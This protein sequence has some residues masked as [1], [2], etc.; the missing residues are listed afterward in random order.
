M[1]GSSL[2][3]ARYRDP[4]FVAERLQRMTTGRRRIELPRR[5]RRHRRPRRCASSNLPSPTPRPTCVARSGRARRESALMQGTPSPTARGE[6]A[7]HVAGREV[8]G[9]LVGQPLRARDSSPPGSSQFSPT[10]PG[11][12]PARPGGG[13]IAALGDQ[14]H[15]GRRERLELAPDAVAARD[16]RRRRRSRAAGRSGGTR[17][18]SARSSASTGVSR[19]FVIAV[20]TPL[21]PVGPRSPA[22]P[23][24]DGLVVHPGP[25]SV[26]AEQHV[27]H[28]PLAGRADALGLR[29]ARAP[30]GTRR[31]PAGSPPRCPRPTATGGTAATTVPA[32]RDHV[33]RAG[34]SPPLAGSVG[35]VTARIANATALT[36][37]A[38]TAL[39]LPGR[40][41]S[42][43]VKS[44]VT[45]S[46]SMRTSTTMRVGVCCSG[47]GPAES[48]TSVAAKRPSGKSRE[49]GAHAPFAV[50]EDLGEQLGDRRAAERRARARRGAATPSALAPRCASR[51][52]ASLVGRARRRPRRA[53][54]TRRRRASAGG[55]G[56]PRRWSTRRVASSPVPCRRRR[57]GG[58]GWRPSRRA[59]R[60]RRT[61]ATIV[62]SLRCVPPA[63]G[64]LSISS[65]AQSRSARSRPPPTRAWSRG[66]RGCARPARAARRSA[67]NSAAEQSARS[68]MLGLDAARRST[69]PIS[70]A[71]RRQARTQDLQLGRVHVRAHDRTRPPARASAAQPSG[72]HSVQSGSATTA[73]PG[74]G[75][76]SGSGRSV[77][78]ERRGARA[79]APQRDDLDVDAGTRVP[80]ASL[81][82]GGEL[83]DVGH[84]ELV[85]LARVPAVEPFVDVTPGH[86]RGGTRGRCGAALRRG[87]RGTPASATTRRSLA[88]PARRGCRV[89][90]TRRH[91]A[92]RPRVPMP[93]SSAT[94]HAC[95][96]PAPPNASSA[97][98]TRIDA[99]LDRDHPHRARHRGVDDRD[100]AF[101]RHA[102]TVERGASG[103]DVE[104]P[105]AGEL[106]ARRDAARAPGRRR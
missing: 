96:G 103:G 36:V 17:N 70:S 32:R 18:G 24:A 78:V 40:C 13:V 54:A 80:V 57:R 99:V 26:A 25:G 82:H 12:P 98:V 23:T 8:H 7:Q 93:S 73:G 9:A 83:V 1:I 4:R 43:P 62:R 105:E 16:A 22:L 106:R 21:M 49:R 63:N 5:A 42:V 61:G 6:E 59:R 72:T 3:P 102:G 45:S 10:A 28:R 46:P 91:G 33:H 55:A 64:S 48:S 14:R 20:C 58:R 50:V 31:R 85:A 97:T 79:R 60:R 84:Q 77:T 94:A 30:R 44:K 51:S 47:R 74:A 65:V 19:V 95:S 67:V 87:R 39:T 29:P 34:S 41:A 53:P 104:S 75:A 88:A 76:R 100:H 11:A 15:L 68:L 2:D 37:T 66:A 27:V 101:G 86:E 81:V 52:P 35:S 69:A 89:R 71:H 90:R 38:S 56:L 92:A